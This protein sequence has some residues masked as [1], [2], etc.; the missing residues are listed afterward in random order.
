MGKCGGH[1]LNYVSDVD[2]IFV[3]EPAD[4][5][6]EAAGAARPPPQL[7][8]AP[9]AGL[10]RPHRP[11]ARIWPVDAALRP[12]GK[13]GPLVRTLA[14]HRGY[15]ERWAK[16]WEFQALLKARPVAGDLALG[17]GVRRARSRR[18]CGRPP[19]ATAS[20][21][22]CRRCAAGS[23]EHIPAARGRP[24]AQARPRRAAR[25]RVRGAAAAAGARPRRP[26]RC[27]APTTLAALAALDPRRLRRP[28]GRR[29]AATR[30]TGSC[31][32]SSTGSSCT[33]CAAPTSC[34]TTT[35]ALRRLG[36]SLGLTQ[37]PGRRARRAVAPARPRG[38]PAARE[39]LLPAA[40]RRGR[41]ARRPTRR[42]SRPRRP[43]QRLAAL[44]YADPAGALRHLEA[45]TA[46]VSPH[47]PAI[48]R[49]LLP[50]MLG[51]FADA[52][53]PD[54]G[55]LGFRRISARRSARTHW[56]LQ[57]LRDEG[58]GR[59]SGWRTLL[60]TQ[61]LRHRPAAARAGGRADARRRRRR[62]ARCGRGALR[63]EMTGRRAPARRPGR[64]RSPR[65]ARSAAASCSGSR[66]PTCSASLDVDAVGDALTDVDGRDPRG[67]ARPPPAL[68]IEAERRGRCRPGSRSSAMGRFGGDE[69]GY[70]SDADVLFVHD[71][72]PG[73]RARGRPREAARDVANELRRLLVAAR[74]RPG[75][76][77]STPTCAPRASRGRWCAPSTSYAAYYA[78]LVGGLGGAGAAARRARSPATR[79]WARRFTELIDPLRFPADGHQRGR[80][81]RGPPDQGPGRRRAAAARRRPG[82]RTSSSGRGGLAD[83]EWTVQLLQLRHAG[84]S[85]RAAH[86]PHPRRARTRPSRPACSTAEDARRAVARRGG[87]PA[88]CATRS[89]WSAASPPT[90]CRATPASGPRS[91]TIRGYPPGQSDELR[92]RLPAGDPSRPPGRRAGVLGLTDGLRGGAAPAPVSQGGPWGGST[93]TCSSGAGR[94]V[95]GRARECASVDGAG[96]RAGGG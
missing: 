40:A 87:R 23:I 85:A 30:P 69:L 44:G 47:A 61:P 52:P 55:L 94:R 95:T 92:Q 2:V 22:T 4:G 16:T 36:R 60:A 65:C 24:A 54:A 68:A 13:A 15:Y 79:T 81:P 39:A 19:S 28:R 12:E 34:P 96:G 80:R 93:R 77:A 46:G 75:A 33:S 56:Y 90:R 29:G 31:A 20:S 3:A 64:R 42:G 74:H 50:V 27:A 57:L 11:R 38:A 66:S 84:A 18:W 14:S 45:L 21:P 82:H 59:R 32:R 63:K 70:G 49:T 41:P 37:R 51:W 71:P 7:A 88:G 10:L 73:A 1:E 78:T 76:A 26:S 6:D 53:D 48:Q 8:V 86:H 91:R 72:L 17:A 35:T 25:R 43:R 9:D 58:A 89:P 5:A 67:G 62:C 83:V